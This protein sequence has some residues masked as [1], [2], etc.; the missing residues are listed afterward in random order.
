MKAGTLLALGAI[1]TIATACNR[2]MVR[3]PGSAEQQTGATTSI[4]SESSGGPMTV[5]ELLRGRVAG[6]QIAALPGGGYS[7]SIRNLEGGVQPLFL[8][9]GIEVPPQ[10]LETALA[11]L[12]RD[13]IRK[14]EVL[15]DLASTA[16]YG[17][18]GSGGVVLITT[19]K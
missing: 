17:V 11:G 14:V 6:L 4:A 1:A 16:M 18:R 15:K 12:T 2:R 19:R 7:Y 3:D 8:V 10:Q 5:D 13:D 9:D